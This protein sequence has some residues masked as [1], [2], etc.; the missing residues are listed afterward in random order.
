M[1]FGALIDEFRIANEYTLWE[2]MESGMG[3]GMMDLGVMQA[4]MVHDHVI[5]CYI[6]V[7]SIPFLPITLS[8]L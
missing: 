2:P 3:F 4:C 7:S 8:R 5:A 6:F 1:R